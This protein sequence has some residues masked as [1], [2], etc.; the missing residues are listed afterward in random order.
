MKFSARRYASVASALSLGVIGAS[1]NFAQS[2]H[3][4][5]GVPSLGLSSADLVWG[6]FPRG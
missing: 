3:Y 1:S 5:T 6:I 2:S 4:F